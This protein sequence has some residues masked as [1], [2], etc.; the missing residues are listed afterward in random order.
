MTKCANESIQPIIELF[1]TDIL[2]MLWH[3]SDQAQ[4]KKGR[5]C[6]KCFSFNFFLLLM[7]ARVLAL[8]C[9]NCESH[10]LFL[11]LRKCLE[12]PFFLRE[13]CAES[14]PT[15]GSLAKPARDDFRRGGAENCK[16]VCPYCRQ[17]EGRQLQVRFLLCLK[18]LATPKGIGQN[19]S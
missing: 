14:V 18:E 7:L 16:E 5:L 15:A 4:S 8:G 6:F 12:I 19:A 1:K 17:D 3:A 9:R 13:K 10:H 2:H 11:P